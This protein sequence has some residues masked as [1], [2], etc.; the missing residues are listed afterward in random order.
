MIVY[1]SDC[2]DKILAEISDSSCLPNNCLLYLGLKWTD[3]VIYTNNGIYTNM[4]CH[5][6][7]KEMI[8]KWYTFEICKWYH[9]NDIAMIFEKCQMIWWHDID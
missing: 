6:H 4:V 2:M 1:I 9:N 7:D 5:G 8:S 3:M